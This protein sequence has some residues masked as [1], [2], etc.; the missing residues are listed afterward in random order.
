MI[1]RR[2]FTSSARALKVFADADAATV[3]S[4][5]SGKTVLVDFFATWC[6]P[7]K[8]LSPAL[9]SVANKADIDLIEVD[10]DKHPD[11][12]RQ[13]NVRAMPTVVA[14]KDGKVR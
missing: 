2:A 4:E 5:S 13:F 11:V 10:V 6:Q 1:F 8:I 7:C 12:A 14:V 9:H 3:A